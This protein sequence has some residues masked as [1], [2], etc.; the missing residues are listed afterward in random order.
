ML[1]IADSI[2]NG[3][4]ATSSA[5]IGTQPSSFPINLVYLWTSG[6]QESV[7]KFN[8]NKKAGIGIENFK[9]QMRKAV[10]QSLPDATISFE[11]GD[12]VEQVL[13]LGSNNPIEI[14]VLGRDL[15]QSRKVA[16]KLN[17]KLKGISYLRDVQIATP[18]DYPGIKIDIDRVKAGQLGLTVDQIS[19]S[20]V[21]ATSSSR[22]TQPNYWLDKSSGIAYQVQ[23]EYPQYRMNSKDQLGLVPVSGNVSNPVYLR[24]VATMQKITSPGE[25]DRINQ[26]RFITIT[27]NIYNK[28]LGAAIKE[29]NT[30]IASLGQLPQGVKIMVRGQAEL[31]NETMSELQSGLLIAIIVIL[32]MLAINFQSFK[33]SFTILSIIP[34][35]VA[36]SVLLLF[37]T[38]KTLNIQSYMGTIMAVGV[39]V[40]NAILFITNAEY[41]R[42]QDHSAEY[43]VIG[44]FNRLRPILMTSL[45][46]IA[47]MIPMAIGLGEGGDQTAPLGIAVIG[48]LIF[49]SISTLMFLPIVYSRIM[50]K[51]HYV[52][53]SL[54]PEDQNSIN[55]EANS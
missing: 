30:T 20:T 40:A 55:Y 21:A 31:F 27:A 26:Q 29:V 6:P 53:P 3:N 8:L 25:Y 2:T 51:K 16:E 5:F 36:G 15:T 10:S 34:A 43:A 45:A 9:E 42:K 33:L 50:G 41:H 39:A 35:V 24:D 49:S 7:I 13:N 18:L 12:L 48:G 23:V 1:Q 17:N 14:A 52:N 32:L 47:G 54:D 11:P 4:I 22:F 46:M 19:K 38:G 37:V 28:D 44:A